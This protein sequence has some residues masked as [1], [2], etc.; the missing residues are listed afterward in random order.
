M[1]SVDRETSVNGSGE[2]DRLRRERDFYREL[3]ELGQTP[4]LEPLLEQA[5][6]LIVEVAGARRGYLELAPESG[7]NGQ[8]WSCSHN[9]SEDDVVAIRELCSSGIVAEAVAT[10]TTINTP[11]AFDDPR[12]SSRD[13]VQANQIS[14]VLCVPIGTSPSLGV[15]YLQERNEPGQFPDADVR[16]AELFARQLAPY[17]DRLLAKAQM[18]VQRDPTTEIRKTFQCPGLL[19]KSPAFAHV[20]QQAS[21]VAPLA[22]GVL[23]TGPAGSGKTALAKAIAQN[24]PWADGPFIEVNCAALPDDLLESEL[25]GAMKGAHSTATQRVIGKVEAADGGTLFLDEIGEISLK[26]QAKLLQLL[27]SGEYF[28][29]AAN[30]PV[31]ADVRII[32]A[33]NA[34]LEARVGAK[35]FRDDLYYRLNVMPIVM[36]DLDNRREDIADL[37]EFHAARVCARHR[38]PKIRPAH[39]TLLYCEEMSWPGNIRELAN[40]VEAGIVRANGERS[41]QLLVRHMF[42]GHDE[43]DGDANGT[44]REATHAFQGRLLRRKLEEAGW[45][46][47]EVARQLDLGR[48]HVY[49]LINRYGFKRPAPGEGMGMGRNE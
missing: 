31:K 49:N 34:D 25:F 15:V 7:W 8:R 45:N 14:A 12:F 5:L 28:P 27:N 38:F 29:L 10:G 2:L 6:R 3:L 42:P 24:S 33:T 46:I 17:A 11:C 26:A 43:A 22:I 21:L 40:T 37:V 32:S 39:A 4:N 44:F 20:L 41:D 35:T 47:V 23:I 30:K 1:L 18:R 36:P 13:S 19:G 48:A 16:N 9:L